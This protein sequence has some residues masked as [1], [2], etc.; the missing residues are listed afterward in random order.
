MKNLNTIILNPQ[1]L[2]L[3]AFLNNSSEMLKKSMNQS[4]YK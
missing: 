3:R 1:K 4:A 2:F